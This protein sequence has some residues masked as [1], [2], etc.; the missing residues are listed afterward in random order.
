M[1]VSEL[2]E[3]TEPQPTHSYTPRNYSANNSNFFFSF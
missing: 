1:E 2:S 3:V